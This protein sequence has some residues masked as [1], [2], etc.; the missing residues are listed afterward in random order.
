MNQLDPDVRDDGA[1][2]ASGDAAMQTLLAER[3]L[4]LAYINVIVRDLHAAEDLLQEALVLAMRQ[5]FSGVDH[6]RGWI[7]VTARN[8]S[9]N[10]ARRADRRKRVSDAALAQ[11]EADWADEAAGPSH[12]QRLAA[13]RACSERLSP[14]ARRMIDLRFAEG[15]S[16]D[17]IAGT[18]GKP[19]NTIYVGM[20]RL[21]ARLAECIRQRLGDA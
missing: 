2:R 21:Y 10:H 18:L 1:D 7:R 17:A 19:V 6:A 13:L 14:A 20:S 4:L 15:R 5:R 11:L 12:G 16:C 3:G 9:L 8:L